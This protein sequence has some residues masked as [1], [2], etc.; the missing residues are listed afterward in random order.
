MK[1]RFNFA[2]LLREKT[3]SGSEKS[4]RSPIKKEQKP[5]F[6]CTYTGAHFDYDEMFGKL[7][8]LQRGR[9]E[10]E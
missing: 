9:L 10:L 5:R 4:A 8:T 6:I 3:A 2:T 1:C 7:K